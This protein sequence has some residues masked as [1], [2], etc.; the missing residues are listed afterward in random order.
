M[1][2]ADLCTTPTDE[3]HEN[4]NII[5]NNNNNLLKQYLRNITQSRIIVIHV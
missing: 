4:N 1:S 5:N 3:K 2:S